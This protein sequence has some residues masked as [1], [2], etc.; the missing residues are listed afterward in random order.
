[1]TVRLYRISMIVL[2]L[3]VLSIISISANNIPIHNFRK[4][5]RIVPSMLLCILF[6][7]FISKISVF[8]SFTIIDAVYPN[9]EYST[10]AF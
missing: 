8:S 1:M 6:L 9:K 3:T 2:I 7:F 10:H 4:K 5:C